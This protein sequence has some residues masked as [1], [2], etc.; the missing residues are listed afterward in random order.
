MYRA[1]S[2]DRLLQDAERQR[3]EALSG[4]RSLMRLYDQ[5]PAGLVEIVRGT[6]EYIESEFEMLRSAKRGDFLDIVGGGGMEFVRIFSGRLEEWEHLRADKNIKLRYIG[7]GEDVEHNR[8]ESVIKNESRVIEGI[9]DIVNVSIRPHSVSFNIYKPEVITVR[10]F[11]EA[12]VE[13][14]RALFAV[15]WE[16]AR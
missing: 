16:V 12:A 7:A 2:P 14:Q 8:T 13:S 9:G 15:L 4:V 10:V 11:N 6:E 5:S 3:L 1:T